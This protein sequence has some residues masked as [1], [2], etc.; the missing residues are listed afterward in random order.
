MKKKRQIT[1]ADL[2]CGAGGTSQGLLMA[3][4]EMD[5]DL[6]LI[7]INHWNVAIDTHSVNHPYAKHLCTGIDAVDPRKL[8]PSGRLHVLCASPECTHHSVARGGEP[9]NDQ[10]RSSAWHILRF[11]EALY[12]DNVVIEN[13]PEYISWGP[14][15]ANGRP[16]K[17]KKGQLFEQLIASFRALGYKYI[18][19]RILNCAD[20]GDPTTRRRLFIICR[21][22]KPVRWPE[23]THVPS[24]QLSRRGLFA[25]TR[26]PWRTAREII[27]WSIPSKSIFDRKRPLADKTLLRIKAGLKKFCGL[28][29]DLKRCFAEDLRPFLVVFRNN[30]DAQSVDDPVPTLT[31]MGANVGLVEPFLAQWDQQA[32]N[33]GHRSVDEPVPTVVTKA[34]TGIVEPYLVQAGGPEGKGREPRSIADPMATVVAENHTGLVQPFLLGQQ[35]GSVPRGLGDPVPTIATDGAVSL[36]TPFLTHF[37]GDHAGRADGMTR[38]GSLDAPLPTQD[39]SPRFGIVDPFIVPQFGVSDPRSVE[40]PLGTVTTTSRGVGL[41]EPSVQ[42]YMVT[43]NHGEG[44]TPRPGM[45]VDEPMPTATSKIGTGICEPFLIAYYGT[46]NMSE[47]GEPVPTVTTKPRFGLVEAAVTHYRLDIRFRMLQPREL[48]RAQGFPDE[49]VFTGNREAVVKQIGNAVPPH[50]AKALIL[51]VLQ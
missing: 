36:T 40:R 15:G 9:M 31:T 11:C 38:N 42:P 32:S 1:S 41:A 6:E 37:R 13:V 51:E 18:E 28:D 23:P 33:G 17:S 16:L 26:K 34:N 45:S 30:Q 25:E 50:T 2:F 4:N 19:W 48:A 5:A 12:V 14:L 39:C 29:V 43:V 24:S 49:Y 8:V 35:S 22:N 3:A 10:S 47:A 46:Q 44:E 20:Y 21:R 7:A 27:D